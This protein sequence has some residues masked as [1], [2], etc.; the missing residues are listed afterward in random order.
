MTESVALIT[1]GGLE[2]RI[3]LLR[4][5]RVMLDTD[6]AEIYGV[7]TKRLNEQVRR[8]RS[9]FPSDFM[10]QLTLAEKE[11]VVAKCDHLRRLKFSPNQ[12]YAFTEH[13]AVM[14]AS[15]LSSER[16]VEASV[17][18]VRAFIRMREAIGAHRDLARKVDAL[19]RKYEG[20]FKVV[21]QALRQI[22]AP[23]AVKRRSIGFR[24][25]R[26]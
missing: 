1:A 8:N 13:G 11:E 22:M 4:G 14:L 24:A 15:V 23:P 26:S 12:P 20:Q 7:P 10:F 2:G 6:L 25:A 9:R 19:E 3:L 21:F 5:L 18:I 17:Q 16:A